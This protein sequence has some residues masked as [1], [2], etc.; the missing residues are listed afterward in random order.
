[1]CLRATKKKEKKKER[2]KRDTLRLE[3]RTLYLDLNDER[4]HLTDHGL[5]E[6][7]AVCGGVLGQLEGVAGDN[8][9]DD[10]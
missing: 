2:K 10:T 7:L 5:L 3:P 9:A 6:T 1:M 8:G 4:S